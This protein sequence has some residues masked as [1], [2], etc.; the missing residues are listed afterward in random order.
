VA[1][2]VGLRVVDISVPSSPQSTGVFHTRGDAQAVAAAGPYAFVASRDVG[3][4]VFDVSTPTRPLP[5]ASLETDPVSDHFGVTLRGSLLY[6]AAYQGL[7]VLDVSVPTAPIQLGFCAVPDSG[8]AV[9]VEGTTAYV[10]AAEAG[11]RIIDVSD[12]ASPVEIG[13]FAT[14]FASQVAVSGSLAF[15]ADQ[16]SGMRVIDVSDPLAP[17]EIGSYVTP[18]GP[19]GITLDANHAYL[20]DYDTFRVLDITDPTAPVEVG[21]FPTWAYRV[22][23]AGSY[24]YAVSG[25]VR[26]LDVSDPTA[27]VEVGFFQPSYLTGALEVALAGAHVYMPYRALSQGDGFAVL[28]RCEMFADGFECGSTASWAT[29]LP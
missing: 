8:I 23:A 21:S 5:V 20:A 25:A 19:R 15:V 14:P 27:P 22:A 26:A 16:Y 6:V 7:F 1:E 10:A 3:L 18:G 24:A 28:T 2:Q 9:D 13:F 17:V 12:P 29:T 4:R 11:L